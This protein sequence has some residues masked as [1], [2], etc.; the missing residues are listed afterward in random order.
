MN[1]VK[2]T[3]KHRGGSIY[4]I[5]RK[6]TNLPNFLDKCAHSINEIIFQQ[7]TDPKRTAIIVKEWVPPQTS[8]VKVASSKPEF[9]SNRKPMDNCEMKADT[10]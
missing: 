5:M 3:M 9:E 1:H 10:I 2:Q 7:D 6:E 4:E 8:N